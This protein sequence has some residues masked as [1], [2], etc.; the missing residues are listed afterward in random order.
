[1]SEETWVSRI[2]E[3]W[4][5]RGFDV[6]VGVRDVTENNPRGNGTIHYR[7][8]RS[9]MVNGLPRGYRGEDGR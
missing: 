4:R 9:D 5:Q 6:E 3:Y 2:R 1:M 8:I 7:A